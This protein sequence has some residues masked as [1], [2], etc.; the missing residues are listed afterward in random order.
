[1]RANSIAPSIAKLYSYGKA[2]K[3]KFFSNLK[4]TLN[5][6]KSYKYPNRNL[7][8]E[9]NQGETPI[10]SHNHLPDAIRYMMSKLPAIPGDINLYRDIFEESLRQTA[11]VYNPLSTNNDDREDGYVDGI[12]DDFL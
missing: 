6:F 1:M 12:F 4:N 2:G 10:D 11:K 9:G 5:E 8:E 3:I 7:G